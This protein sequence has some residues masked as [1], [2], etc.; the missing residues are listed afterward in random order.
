LFDRYRK[1]LLMSTS[2]ARLAVGLL[3]HRLYA[4][5][6]ERSQGRINLALLAAGQGYALVETFETGSNGL[7]EDIAF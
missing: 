3:H 6:S 4:D 7:K 5:R 1:G 2:F